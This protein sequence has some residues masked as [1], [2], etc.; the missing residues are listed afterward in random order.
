MAYTQAQVDALKA[1]AAKGVL[2]GRVGGE[3]VQF[4]SL[5]ELRR[6]IKVMEDEIAGGAAG[7]MTV[8]YAKATRGL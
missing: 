7:A 1:L 3:E 6:Q 5:G 8:S 2:R 4:Q